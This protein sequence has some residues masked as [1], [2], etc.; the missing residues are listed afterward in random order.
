MKLIINGKLGGLQLP[1]LS[2][3]EL[4]Q[5]IDAAEKGKQNSF[6]NFNDVEILMWYIHEQKH[7][8]A[9]N[10]RSNR[11]RKEYENELRLFIEHLLQHGHEIGVDIQYI[12]EGSLFK[13]LE[14]R[15]LRRYQEWLVSNSPYTQK[16][17]TYSPATMARKTTILKSFFQYLYRMKYIQTD[18]ARGLRIAT[19][20]KDDRPDRDLGPGDVVKALRAFRN[21][22]HHVMFGIVL[23]LSTTGLRNEEFC[24]LKVGDV[25]NDRIRGGHYL[26]VT[27]KGNKKRQI[28][29]KSKVY[30]SIRHF[31]EARGLPSLTEADPTA[32]LFTTSRGTA[33]SPSYLI[34]YM[35]K[36]FKKIE[37][38]MD[39]IEVKLTPH[40]FRHAFAITSRLN[41]V[42]VYDIMRSLGHEKL[43]TTQIYLEKV[44]AREG[45]A[46]NQ[47]SNDALQ[48]FV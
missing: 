41:Q 37:R 46:I 24:Q 21:I 32:P 40:V 30:D 11:T 22:E 20:R 8:D 45:H 38:E 48:G 33:F 44:F 25:N 14:P 7:A 17:K 15:H 28:P 31:R 16:G 43:E 36:E 39:G 18:V 23:V 3:G 5:K 6:D 42:D 47:W 26:D 35:A 1:E 27:G 34:S 13:S 10:D 19:V 12:E 2:M 29:L 9:K 4:Q